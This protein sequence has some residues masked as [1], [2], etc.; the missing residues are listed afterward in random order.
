MTRT[1]ILLTTSAATIGIALTA[2]ID[3][4][5]KLVWNASASVPLGLYAITPV[6]HLKVGDRVAIDLPEPLAQFLATRGYLPRGVP[7]L[8][9]VAALSGQRVCRIDNK[10]IIDGVAIGE[11]RERDRL[12]RELP[13]WQGCRRFLDGE[14]FLMNASVFDSFDGRY[15]GPISAT[16]IIGKAHPIWT[17][18]RGDTRAVQ[19]AS[20]PQSPIQPQPKEPIP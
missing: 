11:A 7:L 17:D 4:P 15:F 2:F 13:I 1:G 9:T 14:V 6:H 16:A 19:S 20:I 10:I 12:G 18:E 8:K 5:K 3:V